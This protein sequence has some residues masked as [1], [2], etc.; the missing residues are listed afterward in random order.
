MHSPQ[1][2][3]L[4]S[5][6]IA[7]SLVHEGPGFPFFAPFV[8]WYIATGCEQCALPYVSIIEDLTSPCAHIVT[9]V[10]RFMERHVGI[11][12]ALPTTDI[13]LYS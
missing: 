10:H 11:L 2:L 9:Q 4:M 13:I 8:Y 6:L 5:N 1:V 12:D 7:H 3:P